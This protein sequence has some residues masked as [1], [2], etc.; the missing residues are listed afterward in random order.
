[1]RFLAVSD[2]A[3]FAV[4]DSGAGFSGARHEESWSPQ[5][6]R[7]KRFQDRRAQAC[8]SLCSARQR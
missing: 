4:A 1:M 6:P 3:A 5:A 7:K 8:A 2:L